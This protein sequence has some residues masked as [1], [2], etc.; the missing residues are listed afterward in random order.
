M[1]STLARLALREFRPDGAM[2]VF[3]TGNKATSC[4]TLHIV[5]YCDSGLEERVG[6]FGDSITKPASEGTMLQRMGRPG[7]LLD[8]V[9]RYYALG[10]AQFSNDPFVLLVHSALAATLRIA[11]MRLSFVPTGITSDR[12]S[13]LQDELR[14]KVLLDAAGELTA[15]GRA[16]AYTVTAH[17][18]G[19]RTAALLHSPSRARSAELGIVRWGPVPSSLRCVAE[20]ERGAPRSNPATS[21][22]R[23]DCTMYHEILCLAAPKDDS[24]LPNGTGQSQSRDA[25]I[26]SELRLWQSIFDDG[27]FG[28]ELDENDPWF[29]IND[30]PEGLGEFDNRRNACDY[31]EEVDEDDIEGL[32]LS[33]IHI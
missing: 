3:T 12:L 1:Q 2:V 22:P 29:R 33:L 6:E 18:F 8:R 20:L 31:R 30:E 4:L 19:F 10:E 26:R 5:A 15:M 24:S 14:T 9:V 7:R 11:S 23:A 32:Y 28:D 16:V 25:L 13:M 17:N 27:F 21:I